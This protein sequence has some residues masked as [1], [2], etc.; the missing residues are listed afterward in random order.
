M[1]EDEQESKDKSSQEARMVG[2]EIIDIQTLEHQPMSGTFQN[3]VSKNVPLTEKNDQDILQ[4]DPEYQ[5]I[6]DA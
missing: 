6:V 2:T 1:G 4:A 3:L 5:E